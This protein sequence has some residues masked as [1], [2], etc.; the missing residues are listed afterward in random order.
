MLDR[1]NQVNVPATL[2]WDLINPDVN[3]L[4]DFPNI[5]N[6]ENCYRDALVHCPDL[7]KLVIRRF[8]DCAIRS[9]LTLQSETGRKQE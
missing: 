6:C 7:A 5:L 2:P 3:D 4:A 9:T 1:S 8:L